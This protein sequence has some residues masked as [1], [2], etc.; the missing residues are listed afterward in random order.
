MTPSARDRQRS[1]IGQWPRRRP[2]TH[3]GVWIV[4]VTTGAILLAGESVDPV[5]SLTTR[6]VLAL[7]LVALGVLAG[8]KELRNRREAQQ[9]SSTHPIDLTQPAEASQPDGDRLRDAP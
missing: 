2:R 5:W 4:A 1:A 6:L 3:V 8:S 9:W 7:A